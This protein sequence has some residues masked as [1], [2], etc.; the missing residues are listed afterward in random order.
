MM[1]KLS[2]TS[3]KKRWRD[4]LVLMMG[5]IIA[6]AIFYMFQTV[7]L[8]GEFVEGNMPSVIQMVGFVFQFGAVLL[9]I[10]TVVY[11]LYA[12]SFLLSM[13]KKEYGMYMLLGAKKRKIS[14]MIAIET[15]LI[16]SMALVIGGIL[17]TLLSVGIG[18]YLTQLIDLPSQSY[19]PFI[20]MALIVTVVFFVIL[21]SITTA[22]NILHFKRTR[23][24]DLLY[25][26][27]TSERVKKQ[28][29]MTA[30]KMVTAIILLAIGYYCMVKINKLYLAGVVIAIF[31]I[32]PGTFLFFNALFPTI[33][34][35]LKN[36]E[37]YSKRKLKVFTLSQLSFKAVSLSRVLGLVAMLIALSLGA[38]TVGQ[39]FSSFLGDILKTEPY[40]VVSYNP[41]PE[42]KKEMAKI[43]DDKTFVYHVK[44]NNDKNYYNVEEFSGQ[45]LIVSKVTTDSGIDFSQP[46][47]EITEFKLN[48][49]Y[50]YSS[51]DDL[52]IS[53]GFM[54]LSNK[55]GESQIGSHELLSAQDFENMSGDVN[56]VVA[57]IA[58]DFQSDLKPIKTIHELEL[59][60]SENEF[61]AGAKI[62]I[63]TEVNAMGSGFM[64]MGFFLGFAFLAMLASCLMFKILS[65]AY[66]DVARYDMLH[67]IGV[68][69]SVLTTSICKEIFVVF[70]VPALLGLVHVLVGMQMFKVFFPNPYA[71]ITVP[72]IMFGSI[73]LIYY[74]ITV[75]LYKQIVLPKKKA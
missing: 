41:T 27:A 2:L 44:R 43:N 6:V 47:K 19:K 54:S 72:F 34:G 38:V 50:D 32:T 40:D 61:N 21:F 3:V 46:N 66:Q 12:N 55:Y 69:R 68:R 14:Q 5:L 53:Q 64:F 48:H 37:W 70:G 57:V 56:E 23:T 30:F 17:G 26:E 25:S 35:K 58:K 28:P 4:Y 13:R 18:G 39:S 51:E 63:Y 11:V 24:L 60:R 52:D 71:Y 15:L 65:S 49:N 36:W 45:P 62:T 31:T 7:S 8:N 74:V 16:G 33:I 59:A 73:Y 22:I 42:I 75:L 10:I 67:K 29:L 9:G 20:P 1:L